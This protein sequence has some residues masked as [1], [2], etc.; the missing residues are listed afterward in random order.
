M[1]QFVFIAL[2]ILA[3]Q[4]VSNKPHI[5]F[6]NGE[7]TL[8]QVYYP[9][10]IIKQFTDLHYGESLENDVNTTRLMENIVEQEKPDFLSFTGDMVAGI[11]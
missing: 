7:F 11:P 8:I 6:K 3:V 4:A 5:Q 1:K 10:C 9:I 2:L